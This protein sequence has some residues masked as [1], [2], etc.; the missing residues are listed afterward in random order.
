[1]AR[2]DAGRILSGSSCRKGVNFHHGRVLSVLPASRFAR[3]VL[4]L[5]I[6]PLLGAGAPARADLG[7]AWKSL[8]NSRPQDVLRSD[9]GRE[10]SRPARL[11]WAAAWMSVQPA[12]DENMRAAEEIFAELAR[13]DDETAAEA[14]YLRARLHQ[15]H[16]ARPDYVRAAELYRELAARQPQ[17]HWAQLGLVKLAMLELYVLPGPAA[18]ETDRLAPAE[19]R[20]AQIREPLLQRD[21]HLQIGQAGIA[22]KQPLTRLL[23]HLVAADRI[24]GISGTAREDLVVQI[25]ELSRRAGLRGQA[26]E[27]FER[28]LREYPNNVRAYG[29][30]LKLA[31][32]AP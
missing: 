12:V 29:V 8:A 20:L 2:A 21:L 26:R 1:V 11:A 3:P 24:G 22:L 25:G 4:S 27:Y 31:E 18:V 23:P 7:Q 16:F 13:G 9:S 5:L 10:A 28:Y 19:A 32:V 17:S 6:L 14:A 30:R 15:L